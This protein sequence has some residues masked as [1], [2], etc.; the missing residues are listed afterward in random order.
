MTAARPDPPPASPGVAEDDFLA[1]V[2]AALHDRGVPVVPGDYEVARVVQAGPGAIDRFVEM[3]EAAGMKIAR[4]SNDEHA[5]KRVV[6]ILHACAA[7]RVM[8]PP[9]AMPARAAIV[10]AVEAA[11]I[12]QS[13]TDSQSAAFETDAGI[14]G[15]RLAVAETGSLALETGP[16]LRRLASL[17]VPVHIAVLTE[18]QI[19]P[20][21]I[22]WAAAAP[23][24]MPAGSVL[25]TGPSKTADIEL[26]LVTGV[27][28]PKEVHV[29]LLPPSPTDGQPSIPNVDSQPIT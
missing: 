28:G 3:A 7:R 24:P 26:T 27:H 25:I 16:D 10:R 11:G 9:E 17:A 15:V 4:V 23:D 19:V 6:E 12:E 20:D 13:D 29:V 22:D 18:T 5:A 8:I 21:L 2:R 1:C 14:T